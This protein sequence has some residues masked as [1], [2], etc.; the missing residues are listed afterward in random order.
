M[1]TSFPWISK[2]LAL[3]LPDFNKTY[4]RLIVSAIGLGY[5]FKLTTSFVLAF[6]PEDTFFGFD[7]LMKKLIEQE[8]FPKIYEYDGYWLDIG[9]PEDYEI[10]INEYSKKEFF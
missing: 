6:I 3:T 8:K 5:T 2:I 9:R 10:A 7:H 4:W 1:S